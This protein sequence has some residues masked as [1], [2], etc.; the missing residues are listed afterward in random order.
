M[1][2][3]TTLSQAALDA[4]ERMETLRLITAKTHLQTHEEQFRVLLGLSKADAL[5]VIE[6]TG[7]KNER[8]AR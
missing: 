1:V 8:G 2:G 4:I 6:A 5:A 3:N 7:I